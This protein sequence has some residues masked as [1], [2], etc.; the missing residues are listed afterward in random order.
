MSAHSRN[1]GSRVEREIAQDLESLTGIRFS[2][3]LEQ[4]RSADQGDLIPDDPAW[5]FAIEIKARKEA[6]P[7]LTAWKE[8]S[9]KAAAAC[10]KLPCVVMKF[11]RTKPRVAVPFAA[12]ARAFGGE[13]TVHDWAEITLDG[14]AFLAREMMAAQAEVDA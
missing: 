4:V 7:C 2:R 8:Q 14:L 5:P 13:S 3:N 12:I 1:K 11:D 10:S 9:T 6:S